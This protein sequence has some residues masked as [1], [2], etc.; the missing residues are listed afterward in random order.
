MF[1]SSDGRCPVSRK[2]RRLRA[3]ISKGENIVAVRLQERELTAVFI[4]G[5][6]GGLREVLEEPDV[7]LD[8]SIVGSGRFGA[9]FALKEF[10]KLA[11]IE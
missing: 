1:V 9:G 2:P 5:V 6:V 10:A 4:K 3:E 11:G 7:S 8:I